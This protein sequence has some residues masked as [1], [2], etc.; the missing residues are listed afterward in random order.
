MVNGKVFVWKWKIIGP[1]LVKKTLHCSTLAASS[2]LNV[3]QNLLYICGFCMKELSNCKTKASLVIVLRS[4]CSSSLS[5]SLCSRQSCQCQPY[6][7]PTVCNV[8]S[9]LEKTLGCSRAHL[10]P[11]GLSVHE[12][13]QMSPSV[14]KSTKLLHKKRCQRTT[15]LTFIPG[16]YMTRWGAEQWLAHDLWLP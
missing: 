14:F 9:E 4:R 13:H 1:K 10:H 12:S 6:P 15:F 2:G 11:V 3:D 7:W 5:N 16:W 8:Q